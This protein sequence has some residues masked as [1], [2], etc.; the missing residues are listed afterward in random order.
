MRQRVSGVFGRLQRTFGSLT[1]GQKMTAIIGSA[2]LLVGGVLL[3]RWAAAPTYSPLFNE[4]APAD[5]SAIV[6]QLETD[7]TPY[8]LT[9]GGSTIL[10]PRDQVYDTRI[11]LSGEGLP[12]GDTTGYALLDDQDLSTSQFQEQTDYKRAM[13][14]E[15]A[16]TIEALDGVATSVVHLAIPQEEIFAD[17]QKPTTASVLVETTPGATLD[18][19]QV[20]AV[21]HLVASSVEGLE[22]DQVTVADASG[23]VLSAPDGSLAAVGDARSQ[24]VQDFEQRMS[25]SVQ[26][27]LD[28]V[29]GAGNTAVQVTADL[30]F[31]RTVT[32]TT[33]YFSDPESLPLAA[34]TTTEE[35]TA[36]GG[37]GAG[38]VVGPDGQLDP[39]AA[40][41]DG[42]TS[43][44]KESTT[45]DNAVGKTEED[46][47]AAPGEVDSLHVAVV[48]DTQS[49]GAIEARDV[50]DMVASGLGIN[51]RRGDTVEVSVM[52][53]DR[54]AEEAAAEELA[55]AKAAEEKADL[56]S[57]LRTAALVLLVALLLLGAWLRGR[58]RRKA[59]DQA[60]TYVVEQLRRD[61]VERAEPPALEPS[62]ALA[63][64]S[65]P[66]PSTLPNT[67]AAARDEIAAM[68]E[69]QPEEVAQ[70][71]RGWL[72]DHG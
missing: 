5:A 17:E 61:A 13:E 38:G 71:L 23:T 1:T 16:N 22:P 28:R 56:M 68:V 52:P 67:T 4:L 2:A 10:V 32:H 6:D 11:G 18:P 33:R 62:A 29:L 25:T 30:N 47:E 51:D 43:Y 54:T 64:E 12:A 35:Y 8:E 34:T 27:M 19:D 31:D 3:F 63:L 40:E 9:D 45:S 53:F 70:L 44:R 42:E 57:Q 37:D 60:T 39:G 66:A 69:R 46:R 41:V 7:G 48:L 24:Q 50:E 14:G 49:L 26:S 65:A 20:Q 59:R 36:P 58:K 21:V 72:V 55:A 15:L